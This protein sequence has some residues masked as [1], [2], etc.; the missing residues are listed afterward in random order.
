MHKRQ[1]VHSLSFQ[2]SIKA[3]TPP[4]SS[5]AEDLVHLLFAAAPSASIHSALSL[6]LSLSLLVFLSFCPLS[7]RG[8]RETN[9]GRPSFLASVNFSPMRTPF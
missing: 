9:R 7:V 4:L 5:P 6:S 1:R 2:I 8:G 3:A